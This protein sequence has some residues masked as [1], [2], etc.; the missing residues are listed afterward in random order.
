MMKKAI[1]ITVTIFM[2]VLVNLGCQKDTELCHCE[3]LTGSALLY[4]VL[5]YD[6][7]DASEPSRVLEQY[8]YDESGRIS[9]FLLPMAVDTNIDN[10][11]YYYELYAY[12]SSNQLISKSRFNANVYSP[13]GYENLMNFTYSYADD[14]KL[15][16]EYIE[17]PVIGSF[18][19]SLYY[20][21]KDKL[22]K[23]ERY[24]MD[25]DELE[26]YIE[27]TYD[28][29]GR[30]IKEN[31]VFMA[32]PVFIYYTE[33]SYLNGLNDRSDVYAG[34][35]ESNIEHIREMFKTYDLENNLII[36]EITELEEFSTQPS[37][38]LRY[39]YYTE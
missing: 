5:V 12:N 36:N 16:R 26:S 7:V 17:Y 1:E 3:L 18:S 22:S 21:A 23:M 24:V 15:T 6:S 34:R 8:D 28:Y 37:R 35:D 32:D 30:L 13:T 38:A 31:T 19:Y 14:G 9:R 4:R 33:H 39:E 2:M 29:C 20:Y 27:Y 25:T 10:R 11:L